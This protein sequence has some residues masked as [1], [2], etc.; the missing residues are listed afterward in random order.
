MKLPII[1]S[2]WIGNPFSNIEK[3]C[4]QS[5][6][7]H[8][9]EFH[10]YTYADIGGVPNKAVIKDANE[11]LPES[12]IFYDKR[13]SVT[14]F[15]DWF[16]YA[17]LQN[18]GGFWVDMDMICIRPFNFTD[19]IVLNGAGGD[20]TNSV[21]KFPKG[22]SFIALLEKH[23]REF[24]NPE[25]SNFGS[26]GGPTVLDKFV[27]QHHMQKYIKPHTYFLPFPFEKWHTA[28]DNTYAG[29]PMI[30]QTTHSV[31]LFN[32]MLRLYGFDKNANFDSDSLFEQL[33]AKHGIENLPSAQRI[34]SEQIQVIVAEKITASLTKRKTRINRERILYLLIAL[35]VGIAIGLIT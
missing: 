25:N 28:F 8:G 30:Y 24:Q 5:F 1:Q 16:R 7:D 31:H 33:K 26:V 15:S 21:L 3:L 32:E 4:V 29:C 22:N 23:C 19:E 17:L 35:F 34:T 20:S 13:G 18:H 14:G 9:H 12:E 10:L 2:L 11:I 6:I 27:K